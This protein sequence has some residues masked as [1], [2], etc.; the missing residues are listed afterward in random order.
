MSSLRLLSLLVLGLL[1]LANADQD[2]YIRKKEPKR[3][4]FNDAMRRQ[5]EPASGSK[6]TSIEE[7]INATITDSGDG[8]DG[9]IIGGLDVQPGELPFFGHF[10][11]DVMCGGAL[12]AEDIFVTA[13][14]CLAQGFPAEIKVGATTTISTNEGTR[15]PVC[16]A[17]I[18]PANNMKSMANDIAVLKLCDQVMLNSYAEYNRDH[19]Y[20]GQTGVDVFM[21][22]FGRQTVD[23]GL[24]PILQKAKADYLDNAACSA[25]YDKYNGD[26]TF[27]ADSPTG[28]ICYGDSGSPV[29][30]ATNKVVGFNSYIV[31]T[32]ASSYPDFFTRVSTYAD[33]LDDVICTQAITKPQWCRVTAQGDDDTGNDDDGGDD[34]GT[35]PI[36]DCLTGFLGIFASFFGR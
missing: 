31:D 18:H 10:L 1:A 25:R 35:D 30:D 24:S 9:R 17:I 19:N 5:N 11:G 4:Y 28:G 34:D 13:A 29:M 36:T 12:V 23:D 7:D 6:S 16:S 26:Q 14:H 8:A 15:V 21:V 32:C 2:S 27:C 3:M 33:W 22:G 20:P